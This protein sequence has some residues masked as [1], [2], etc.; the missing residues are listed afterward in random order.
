MPPRRMRQN[1][2]ERL[3]A[4]RRKCWR[5]GGAGE[6]VGGDTR[7]NVAPEVCGCMYKTF[8]VCNPLTFSGTEGAVGLSRWIKKLESVLKL[9]NVLMKIS[10]TNNFHELAAL[11]PSMVTPEYKKIERYVWGLSEK[12]QGNVTSSKPAIAHE[13][14]RMAHSLMDQ[15][16]RF[17]AVRS[18]EASKRKWE[19]YQSDG[20]N[21]NN[22][23]NN[24]HHHQQNRRQ[25]AAKAYVAA[26]TKG[27]V[28]LENLPLCNRCKLHH[29][30]QCSV[31]CRKCKRICHQTK[32]CWS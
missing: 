29:L 20:S 18:G 9:A 31:K 26:P 24:T 2:V 22:N 5:T 7:G 30:G 23:R 10:Y 19:D 27:K 32:D 28:Y 1:A 8:L 11:C 16:V 6:N 21:N 25:E 15:A 14:I 12:I 13:A 3:V 4:D 17:K